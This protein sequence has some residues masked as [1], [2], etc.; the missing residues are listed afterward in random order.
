[1]CCDQFDADS[2][3]ER[4]RDT[5]KIFVCDFDLSAEVRLGLEFVRIYKG[6]RRH[7]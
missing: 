6:V 4:L 5:N 3:S 2:A 1:M 7:I